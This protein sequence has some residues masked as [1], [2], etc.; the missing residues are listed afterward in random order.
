M[1]YCNAIR[2][3]YALPQVGGRSIEEVF[4]TAWQA[5]YR[6]ASFNNRIWVLDTAT[7]WVQTPLLLEDLR[8]DEGR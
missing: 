7:R 2:K 1:T 6:L 8:C 5:G 4:T 3:I